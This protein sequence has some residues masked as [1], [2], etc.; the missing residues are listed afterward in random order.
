M[1]AL[2]KSPTGFPERPECDFTQEWEYDFCN[3]PR[4][5]PPH[6]EAASKII[7]FTSCAYCGQYMPQCLA[8]EVQIAGDPEH[9]CSEDHAN[10]YVLERLREAGL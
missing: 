6:L 10:Q 3:P 7:R 2:T 5:L 4:V 8:L 9:F 1:N